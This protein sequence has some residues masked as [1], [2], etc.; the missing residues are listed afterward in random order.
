MPVSKILLSLLYYLVRMK[1]ATIIICFL[2]AEMGFLHSQNIAINTDGTAA[3]T[4]AM[5]DVKGSNAKATTTTQNI[6]QVKSN[7]AAYQLKL[8]LIL[9]TNATASSMYGGIEVADSTGAGTRTYRSLILQP[10]GGSVGI[11]V[12][13]PARLL[14]IQGNNA[15]VRID[16]D[17]DSPAILFTRTAGGS[18][19]TIWK[20]FS[21]GTSATGVNNGT[22][23]INDL[24][25][26]V[27]GA[28]TPRL[29]IDNVGYVGISASTPS[30]RLQVGTTSSDG[31]TNGIQL[32][33]AASYKYNIYQQTG[34]SGSI[35][36]SLVIDANGDVDLRETQGTHTGTGN[37]VFM[38][39]A[40]TSAGGTGASKEQMRISPLG[41]VGIGTTAP[42]GALHVV[43]TLPNF[44]DRMTNTSNEGAHFMFRKA[45]GTAAAPLAI[46]N[47]DEIGKFLVAAY[48]GTS[49]I[50]TGGI[51]GVVNGTVAAGS[52]PT[53]LVFG[54]SSANMGNPI[55]NEAMRITNTKYVGIGTASPSTPL[56]VDLSAAAGNEVRIDKDVDWIGVGFTQLRLCGKTDPLHMLRIGYST[57][58]DFAVLQSQVA[59]AGIFNPIALNPNGGKVGIGTTTPA[60]KL[61]I[62]NT[63]GGYLASN[64]LQITGTTAD[65]LNYPALSFKGGTLGTSYPAISLTNGGLALDFSSGSSGVYTNRMFM[66]L[67]AGASLIRFG[68]NGTTQ[69]A[70]TSAGDVGIGTISPGA[71]L[72]VAAATTGRQLSVGAWSWADISSNQAGRG[73][74]GG[75]M[76]TDHSPAA[77]KYSDTHGSIGA[78]AFAVNYPSWNQASVITSGTTSSTAGTAFAP[79]TIMTFDYTGKVGIGCTSP[80]YPLHVVGNMG[81]VGTIYATAASV[82]SGV[83]ACSDL[84]YKKDITPLPN[85]L[86]SIMQLKG[87]NYFWKTKEFADKQFATTRANRFHRSGSRKDIPRIGIHR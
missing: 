80:Q 1:K 75:N 43:G 47:G 85:A 19:S 40:G 36:N 87:V 56:H 4:G 41:Y 55:T 9:G 31:R 29:T 45:R 70:I 15:V 30:A 53:D 49:Y 73:I 37:L 16:R 46:Q 48:D 59:G 62:V 44:V 72:H 33:D 68:V 60:G 13:N 21:M 82:T 78:M 58:G 76:Y 24:G 2:F 81:V 71:K 35:Q 17:A 3:E 67:D 77:Y 23:D 10:N 65:N 74:F 38:T 25:S 64:Y 86:N 79:V 63:S 50:M 26:A 28:G 20:T 22:F 14:H 61:E 6:F 11:G 39:G 32:G 66:D 18:F 57:T 52:I 8:R 84:R 12:T 83:L 7:D 42:L 69:A 5:L 51:S 27:S 34:L 54:V